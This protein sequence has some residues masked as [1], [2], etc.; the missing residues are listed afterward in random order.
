MKEIFDEK[1]N[2]VCGWHETCTWDRLLTKWGNGYF[3]NCGINKSF[4]D[5]HHRGF[6]M[7]PKIGKKKNITWKLLCGYFG[8]AGM[9]YHEGWSKKENSTAKAKLAWQEYVEK[10]HDNIVIPFRSAIHL[11]LILNQILRIDI[12]IYFVSV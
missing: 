2:G 9:K 6:I 12:Y 4:G 3:F 7:I 11:Y 5:N 1:S 8:V 10:N